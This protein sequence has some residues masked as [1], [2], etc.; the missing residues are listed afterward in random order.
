MRSGRGQRRKTGN[1]VGICSGELK[2]VVKQS[3][4]IVKKRPLNIFCQHNKVI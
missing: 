2:F 1:V 3:T 4:S